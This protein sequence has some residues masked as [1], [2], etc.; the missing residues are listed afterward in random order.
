MANNKATG[1]G[2]SV[3]QPIRLCRYCTDIEVGLQHEPFGPCCVLYYSYYQIMYLLHLACQ[4]RAIL[5]RPGPTLPWSALLHPDWFWRQNRPGADVLYDLRRYYPA[6]VSCMGGKWRS[7]IL[8]ILNKSLN[9]LNP[10]TQIWHTQVCQIG[11]IVNLQATSSQN[12]AKDCWSCACA[13][14]CTS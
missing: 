12:M 5:T 6:S 7:G 9:H 1:A 14:V 10:Y 8:I 3:M 13:R 4:I 2:C 11:N